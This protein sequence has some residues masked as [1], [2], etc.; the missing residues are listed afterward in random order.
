MFLHLQAKFRHFAKID[1][2]KHHQLWQLQQEEAEGLVKQLLAADRVIHEQQLG[3][4]WQGPDESI[5]MSPH[6]HRAVAGVTTATAA[7]GVSSD[8]GGSHQRHQVTS[9]HEDEEVFVQEAA[10]GGT[11]TSGSGSS[12]SSNG[13]AATNRSN[14]SA[15]VSRITISYIRLC[16][17]IK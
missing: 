9:V 15:E 12:S 6:E 2:A 13:G 7:A 4:Q 17:L 5:F 3:W 8:G 11:S 16:L 1:T 14:G 10:A